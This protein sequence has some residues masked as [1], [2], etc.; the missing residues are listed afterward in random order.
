MLK[1]TSEKKSKKKK[2]NEQR[3]DEDGAEG[4]AGMETRM[5]NAEVLVQMSNLR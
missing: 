1:E 2:R 5:K 3:K 4:K